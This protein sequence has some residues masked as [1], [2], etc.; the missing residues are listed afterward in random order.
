MPLKQLFVFG[1]VA[2]ATAVALAAD[3]RPVREA[4]SQ[5]REYTLRIEPGRLGRSGSTCTATM[6]K[7][8]ERDARGKEL[9]KRPLVN[10]R[11]PAQVFIRNDAKFTITLDEHGRGGARNALVVYGEDGRLLRHYLITDLL[12]KADWRHVRASKRSLD[13]LDD[14]R[15]RFDTPRNVFVIELSWGR[16][17]VL[18]LQ[19]LQIVRSTT[20]VPT[21]LLLDVPPQIVALLESSA[22]PDDD[23]EDDEIAAT[24]PSDPGALAT[25]SSPGAPPIPDC[26]EI[27]EIAGTTIGG[28]DDDQDASASTA[29]EAPGAELAAARNDAHSERTD[30]AHDSPYPRPNPAAPS[31]YVSWLNQFGQ[32]DPDQDA[33]PLYDSAVSQFVPFEGD[34]TL[35]TNALNGDAEALESPAVGAW[36]ESNRAALESFRQGAMLDQRS[37]SLHSEDGALIS[38]LLPDLSPMRQLAKA[39]ILDGRRLAAE[40]NVTEAADRILDAMAAGGHI[41][42]GVTLIENL[43]ATAMQSQGAEALLDIQA[44]APEGALD[45]A[46]L[47]QEAGAAARPVIPYGDVLIGERLMSLDTLQRLYTPGPDGQYVPDRQ[48]IVE[49]TGLVSGDQGDEIQAALEAWIPIDRPG[50]DAVVA[51]VN[52]YFDRASDAVDSPYVSA[53]VQLEALD[54][55]IPARRSTNPLLSQLAPSLSRAHFARTRGE[56]TRRAAVLVANL[57]SYRQQHGSYPDSLGDFNGADFATDPFTG[58]AFVYQ[59]EGDSFRLYSTA[60]NGVDDG[61]AHD[62]KA[63]TGDVVYWPRPPRQ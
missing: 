60:A 44:A 21:G 19:T 50:F 12:S 9:W 42:T 52:N 54:K 40:G 57:N 1:L 55:S 18:D 22:S 31:D 5:N 17:I 4:I 51:D 15:C 25:E 30:A 47:A 20:D 28:P 63:E 8:G 39:S 58:G 59:R 3:G 29:E 46:K 37:W 33:R 2:L 48:R 27:I 26:G 14:A 10:D 45:Y 16:S 34:Q 23:A 56:A 41:G 6:T 13:W 7:S 35:L 61:G 11:A 36:L 43:V 62:P 24:Q 32:A 38:V 53:R 49:F